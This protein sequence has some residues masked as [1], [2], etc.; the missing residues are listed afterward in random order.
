MCKWCYGT[1]EVPDS[2][3]LSGYSK[4]NWCYGTGCDRQA[5]EKA[6]MAPPTGFNGTTRPFSVCYP[7]VTTPPLIEAK[8]VPTYRS[9][10]LDQ[11]PDLAFLDLAR[12]MKYEMD[13]RVKLQ[14]LKDAE[15]ARKAITPEDR[16]GFHNFM[17]GVVHAMACRQALRMSKGHKP[18][19]PTPQSGEMWNA[20]E[21]SKLATDACQGEGPLRTNPLTW[22]AAGTDAEHW[23]GGRWGKTGIAKGP[24]PYGANMAANRAYG[25]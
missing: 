8:P 17:A 12:K 21:G 23:L 24:Y 16:A 6:G 15:A 19:G 18:F 5:T 25:Y 2:L 14:V 3:K 7:P 4:C 1:G 20:L 13:R 9:T 10:E 22:N 11:M